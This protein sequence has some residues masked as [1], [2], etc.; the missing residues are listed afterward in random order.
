LQA[1]NKTLFQAQ[2]AEINAMVEAKNA[3]GDDYLLGDSISPL[4]LYSLTLMRWGG[5]AG[6]D[7]AANNAA[8]WAHVQAVAAHPAVAEVVARE[9]LSLNVFVG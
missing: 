3:R 9:R 1:Y 5:I 2:L 8:L 6:I 7:P 4:D